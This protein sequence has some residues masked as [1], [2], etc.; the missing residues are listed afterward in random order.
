MLPVPARV[1]LGVMAHTP[2]SPDLQ[3]L[4][5]TIRCS[6]VSYPENPFLGSLTLLYWIQSENFKPYWLDEV[7]LCSARNIGLL[8][9]INKL[10]YLCVILYGWIQSL[11]SSK[12][13]TLPSQPCYL[14]LAIR[15]SPARGVM[16][17][18]VGNGHGDMSSSPGRDWWHFT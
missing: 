5:H 7:K 8:V 10:T 1:N 18:V 6:L 16:V 13:V 4:Y 15:I 9:G 14:S 2:H 12:L 17:I 3:N 11:P